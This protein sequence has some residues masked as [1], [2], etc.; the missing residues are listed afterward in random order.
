MRPP[1]RL[2]P[3]APEGARPPVGPQR[4]WALVIVLI[5]LAIVAFLARDSLRQLFA[6][7]TGTTRGGGEERGAPAPDAAQAQSVPH[8]PVERAK[9]VES[10]VQRQAD[11]LRRRIDGQ[12][13]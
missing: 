12:A 1:R 8:T 4:G 5:A 11:D 10:T 13:R 2:S 7:V 6:S 3:C 9:A